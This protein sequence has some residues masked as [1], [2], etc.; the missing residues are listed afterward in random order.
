ME[1]YS[2]IYKEMAYYKK[3]KKGIIFNCI[4]AS[5]F[6][7]VFFAISNGVINEVLRRLLVNI[8]IYFMPLSI[9][10]G[11]VS[12]SIMFEEFDNMTDILFSNNMKKSNWIIVKLFFSVVYGMIISVIPY[13]LNLIIF[14]DM[15]DN[16][17]AIQYNMINLGILI[18]LIAIFIRIQPFSIVTIVFQFVS[19]IIAICLLSII[20]SSCSHVACLL[21][22]LILYLCNFLL[23]TKKETKINIREK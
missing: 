14:K 19:W 9:I 23:L 8:G 15:I 2:L 20:D 5:A 17:L 4:T 22:I 1:L 11:N 16:I 3:N 12:S 18:G 10:M 21:G 13:L 7:M 6:A